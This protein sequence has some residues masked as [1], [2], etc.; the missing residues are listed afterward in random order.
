MTTA[1][2]GLPGATTA[3]AS[4]AIV[5]RELGQELASLLEGSEHEYELFA[6]WD[7]YRVATT[8]GRAWDL[9]L[10]DFASAEQ[11]PEDLDCPAVPVSDQGESGMAMATLSQVL[12]PVA[13][14]AA[15][16]RAQT[17][18]R[19][20]LERFVDG[21]KTGEVMAGQCPIMRRVQ[22]GISR[23]A[24]SDATVL[25]EGPAGSGKSLAA[26][27]IHCK[28]RRSNQQIHVVEAAGN[29]NEDIDIRHHI[30]HG[31]VV[32][33]LTMLPSDTL[34]V[35]R[36]SDRKLFFIGTA[37]SLRQY[38]DFGDFVADLST[39]LGGG[40]PARSI[41]ARGLYDAEANVFTAYKVGIYLLEP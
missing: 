10:Y 24:D 14:I 11:M 36:E 26:R 21:L 1:L 31:P 17:T 37:D 29:G 35:P 5:A 27:M 3:K 28:S 30:K 32:I 7:E 33:D 16:L 38:A 12:E 23:A 34:I 15:E 39:S 8:E 9:A 25:I 4:V 6:D 18:R 22:S 13:A 20:E 19:H 41:F 2:I 40:A